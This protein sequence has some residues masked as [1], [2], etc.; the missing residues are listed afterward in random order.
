MVDAQD[1][2]LYHA[3][4]LQ[5]DGTFTAEVFESAEALAA[6]LKTLV[7]RD[8]SVACYRGQ[9]LNVSKPPMR[10]LMTP[11]GNIPL[12]ESATEIEPDDTGYLGV[13]PAHLEDPPQLGAAAAQKSGVDPD[14]F[15]SDDDAG[16]TIDIFNNAL[17]DPDN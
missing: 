11:T 17:P 14:E 16:D 9:R 4:I 10:Y 12:F 13:D 8:V 5:A 3:V 6:R 1:L 2:V 15:F 7:N